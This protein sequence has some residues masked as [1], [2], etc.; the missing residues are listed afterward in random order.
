[1][2]F[3]DYELEMLTKMKQKE[4]QKAV[5]ENRIN[6][7]SF[8]QAN[9]IILNFKN[10]LFRKIEEEKLTTCCKYEA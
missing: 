10:K 7:K 4:M 6:Y 3:N 2:L 5:Q 9:R 8:L 1:M